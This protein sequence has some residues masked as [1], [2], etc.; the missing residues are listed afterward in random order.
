MKSRKATVA[1]R[2]EV[3]KELHKGLKMQALQDDVSLQKIVSVALNAY[4]AQKCRVAKKLGSA[5]K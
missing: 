4:L 3:S 1:I 2:V 5:K